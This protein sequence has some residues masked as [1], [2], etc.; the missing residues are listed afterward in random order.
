MALLSW[1]VQQLNGDQSAGGQRLSYE[2]PTGSA[3]TPATMMYSKRG[4]NGTGI[5]KESSSILVIITKC[6]SHYREI[7]SSPNE[8]ESVRSH[9]HH[10]VQ[11]TQQRPP[12]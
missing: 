4:T 2:A 3:N 8:L 11:T 1:F 9:Q 7:P 6:F 10:L 5:G 12:G